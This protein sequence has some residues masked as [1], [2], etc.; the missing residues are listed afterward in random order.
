LRKSSSLR[1]RK[2]ILSQSL[3][4]KSTRLP[5]NSNDNIE[6]EGVGEESELNRTLSEKKRIFLKKV[7]NDSEKLKGKLKKFRVYSY[8]D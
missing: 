1:R 2:S 3:S 5:S 6:E 7:M 4:V 8:N